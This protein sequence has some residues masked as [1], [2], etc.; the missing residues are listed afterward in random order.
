[1]IRLLQ[2]ATF[3]NCR[4]PVMN[5]ASA[6]RISALSGLHLHLHMACI[7]TCSFTWLH[8]SPTATAVQSFCIFT[9]TVQSSPPAEV[10]FW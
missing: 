8:M 1:M 10:D 2:E 4:N 7:V 3:S 5:S 6:F 9:R